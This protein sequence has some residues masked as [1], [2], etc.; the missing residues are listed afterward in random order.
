[1]MAR[2]LG[3][4]RAAGLAVLA[5]AW[6]V[7]AHITSAESESSGWGAAL[8]LAPLVVALALALWR[9]PQRWLAAGLG[10]ASVA[11]LLWAWP[12]L[13]TEVAAL[14]YLQHFGIYGLLAVFFGRTLAGPGEPLITQLARRVHGGVLTPKQT[15]YTRQLTLAWAL[16]FVGMVLVSTGLFFWG[17][18]AA[19]SVFA[20]LL[21]GPLIALMF[22]VEFICRRFL[23]PNEPRASMAD[24]V[25]AWR[26]QSADKPH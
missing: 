19:W 16:F 13:K 4:L 10:L 8:A 20:N 5:V 11:A 18:L 2:A 26:E 17:T 21:G 9:L 6:A 22:V 15:V 1:M 3:W 12:Q 25:R 7:A 23:L 24:A 14:Y